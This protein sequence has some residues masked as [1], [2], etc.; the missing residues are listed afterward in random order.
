MADTFG[1]EFAKPVASAD[2]RRQTVRVDRPLSVFG[3]EAKEAEDAQPI[4]GDAPIGIA[5]ETDAMLKDIPISADG[6]GHG[7]GVIDG[8]G[9]DREVTAARVGLP[10]AAKADDSM[11]PIGFDVLAERGYFKAAPIDDKCQRP[12]L[13]AR[14]HDFDVGRLGG[15]GHRL[16]R[17]GGGK[18][19]LMDRD[20]KQRVAYSAADDARLLTGGRQQGEDP[21]RLRGK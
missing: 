5:D 9:I 17:S 7:T 4:L 16:R 19:D 20:P 21:L 13:Y 6:I 12:M 1:G 2:R 8:K 15:V 18:V 11:A 10:V 3:M 14:R